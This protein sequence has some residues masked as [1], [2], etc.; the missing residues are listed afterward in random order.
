MHCWKLPRF[1]CF[2]TFANWQKLR[3]KSFIFLKTTKIHG[4]QKVFLK[5]FKGLPWKIAKLLICFKKIANYA[6]GFKLCY[7]FCILQGG[8]PQM[9]FLSIILAVVLAHFFPI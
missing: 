9:S 2:F 8:N 7:P 5:I 1:F 4:K 3:L 6:I